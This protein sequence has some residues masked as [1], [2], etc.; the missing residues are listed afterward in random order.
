MCFKCCYFDFQLI[1]WLTSILF[2]KDIQQSRGGP[3][4]DCAFSQHSDRNDAKLYGII[5]VSIFHRERRLPIF[6]AILQLIACRVINVLE[7]MDQNLLHAPLPL[8]TK[9]VE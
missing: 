2:G 8:V 9:Q 5:F 1:Q 4:H 7:V 6:F 3:C